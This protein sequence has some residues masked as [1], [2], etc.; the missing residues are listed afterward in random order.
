MATHHGQP[1]QYPK[2][3]AKRRDSLYLLVVILLGAL[4]F[5]A[6]GFAL[7]YC[8]ALAAW[9]LWLLLPILLLIYFAYRLADRWVQPL[10]A[11][12]DKERLQHMRGAQSEAL[13][14]WLLRKLDDDWHVF[15]NVKLER[16]SDVDHVVVGPGGVFCISTKSLRGLFTGTADGL[17]YNNEPSPIARQAIAQAAE[18]ASRLRVG[19]GREVPWVQA[20]LAVPHGY[21]KGDAAGGKVWVAHQDDLVKRL[22][23]EGRSRK[24]TNEQVAR[25]VAVMK[26]IQENAAAVYQR[27]PEAALR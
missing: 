2:G 26:M 19:M 9:G 15:D 12:I 16:E 22:A 14:S 11:K 18:V 17:L 20:V 8:V 5:V 1:G 27:P 25:V 13:V 23:P 10:L 6:L 7:G 3:E 24:L 21:V 4:S